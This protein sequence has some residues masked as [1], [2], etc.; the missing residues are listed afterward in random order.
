MMNQAMRIALQKAGINS[1]SSRVQPDYSPL[2]YQVGSHDG[3]TYEDYD[4]DHVLI[5]AELLG[6]ETELV[7]WIPSNAVPPKVVQQVRPTMRYHYE[8]GT[9]RIGK[10]KAT[11]AKSMQQ[12]MKLKEAMKRPVW[13]SP[14]ESKHRIGVGK[15]GLYA[16]P[17]GKPP[18]K[19]DTPPINIYRLARLGR[20][21]QERMD[22]R[23]ES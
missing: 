21:A 16:T 7:C 2:P 1:L 23:N 3:E 22:K 5:R 10:R 4:P 13:P 18:V 11:F 8:D 6:W 15:G 20:E 12:S 19:K 14:N 17:S 9:E